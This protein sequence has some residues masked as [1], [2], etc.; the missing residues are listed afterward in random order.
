MPSSV[1]AATLRLR[2]RAGS[3]SF[4]SPLYVIV[5]PLGVPG[6]SHAALAAQVIDG[7]ARLLQL[8]AKDVPTGALVDLAR[9]VKALTDAAGAALIINDRADVAKL[10]EAAGVHLGQ[11]DLPPAAAREILGPD[12]VIGVSTHDVK[13]AAAA[14]EAG[15]ADYLGFGPIFPTTS[16]RNPDPLQ[17]LDGLRRVRAALRRPMP[18]VAIGGITAATMSDVLAAGA[19]A[20]AMIGEVVRAPDVCGRVRELLRATTGGADARPVR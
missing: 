6:R 9:A 18:I 4:P 20:V 12:K 16:K 19:D 2:D 8:R 3:F 14:A 10:V 17:G 11:E 5:D 7:G 15:V 1:P 13:Q